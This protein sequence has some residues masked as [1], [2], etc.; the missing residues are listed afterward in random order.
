M[1]KDVDRLT[2][3]DTVGDGEGDDDMEGRESFVPDLDRGVGGSGLLRAG[4]GL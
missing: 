1:R 3:G 4:E 2:E